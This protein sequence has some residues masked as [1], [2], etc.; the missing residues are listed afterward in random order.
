MSRFRTLAVR[1]AARAQYSEVRD[2]IHD[3][4][5][6]SVPKGSTVVV[7]SKGDDDLVRFGD[8]VGWHF[9]RTDAG[10]YAGHYPANGTA[11]VSHLEELRALGADYFLLPSTYA[12]WLEYYPELKQHLESRCRV[13]AE[14]ADAC[15][16]YELAHDE[17]GTQEIH[18]VVSE[19]WSPEADAAQVRALRLLPPI[20]SLLDSIL[21]DDVGVLV[22][23][24]GDDAMLD[25]GRPAHHYLAPSSHEAD[26]GQQCG[27]RSEREPLFGLAGPDFP[28]LVI[29]EPE[30]WW[31]E[32][33]PELRSQLEHRCRLIAF[34]RKVSAIFQ[35]P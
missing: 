34:R 14:D 25:V 27:D 22:A 12:W 10:L 35:L 3:L 33:T 32:Q 30:L 1:E 5:R 4:V 28:Y 13:I 2:R 31:A 15:F 20:R 11:A 21:P 18:D 8:C 7:V 24:R 9:P 26:A 17:S 6:T 19:P 29:P 16:L 23:A